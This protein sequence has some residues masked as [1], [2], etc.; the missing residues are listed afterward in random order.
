MRT[1]RQAENS[2]SAAVSPAQALAR[3]GVWIWGLLALV[4]VLGAV[5]RLQ[6]EQQGKEAWIVNVAGRQRMLVTQMTKAALLLS[7]AKQPSVRE[8][9]VL[10]LSLA[11]TVWERAHVGLE[12]GDPSLDLPVCD[13]TDIQ[14]QFHQIDPYFYIIQTAAKALLAT[15]NADT[16]EHAV[17]LVDTL[18]AAE[19]PFL[20][21]MEEITF[22]YSADAAMHQQKLGRLELF[23]S[24][25][26]LAILGYSGVFIFPPLLRQMQTQT[27]TLAESAEQLRSEVAARE[28]AEAALRI[29][30]ERYR[31]ICETSADYAFSFLSREDGNM[32]F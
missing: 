6:A 3:R 22:L 25:L 18:V 15:T 20:I 23:W 10:E 1:F 14:K 19:K 32:E 17:Q 16:S 4:V 27:Q 28:E 29:S 21:G 26:T 31:A 30:E 13:N 2:K 12:H 11:F 5:F 7:M 9:A 24:F 8:Q